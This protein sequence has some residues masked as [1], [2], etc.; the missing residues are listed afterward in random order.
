MKVALPQYSHLQSVAQA[1]HSLLIG[2]AVPE[3]VLL[4]MCPSSSA[5]QFFFLRCQVRRDLGKLQVLPALLLTGISIL[6]A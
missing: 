4:D 5:M 2:I 3:D 6:R 1:I